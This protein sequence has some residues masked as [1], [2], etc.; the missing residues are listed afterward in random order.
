MSRSTGN[1]TRGR[2]AE[3]A[4]G[5]S[6]PIEVET[7]SVISVRK[8]NKDIIIIPK[9]NGSNYSIWSSTMEVFLEYRGLWYLFKKE[10]EEP[11]DEATNKHILEAWLILSSKI[12]PD[13]F[14]SI[15]TTCGRSAYKIWE[16]LKSN[17]ATASIYGIY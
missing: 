13:I 11:I 16:R 10:P 12:Y 7:L 14:N 8:D 6:N 4:A 3:T 2:Q 1:S 5:T 9:F 17:Y 15:K